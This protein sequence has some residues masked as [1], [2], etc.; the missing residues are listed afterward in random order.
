VRGEL[1]E[2]DVHHLPFP[3]GAFDVTIAVT[4]SATATVSPWLSA[5]GHGLGNVARPT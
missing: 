2:A 3:D 1:V 5:N 4:V